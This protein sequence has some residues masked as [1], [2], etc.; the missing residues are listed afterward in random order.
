[1]RL[2]KVTLTIIFLMIILVITIGSII[3]TIIKVLSDLS[4][5]PEVNFWKLGFS[6]FQ[7]LI[8]I[9]FVIKGLNFIFRKTKVQKNNEIDL[10]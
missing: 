8:A 3:P 6:V 5:R 1:M 9:Y 7:L 2:L 4:F 10:D